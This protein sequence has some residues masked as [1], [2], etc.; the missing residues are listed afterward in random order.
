MPAKKRKRKIKAKRSVYKGL[1]CG[2]RKELRFLKE[3]ERS[4][5]PLPIKAARTETPFGFYT[6]DFEYEEMFIEVKCKHTFLVLLGEKSYLSTGTLSVLQ[7][8]KIKWVAEHIK[9]VYIIVYLSKRDSIPEYI[10]NEKNIT[11]KFKGGYKKKE[12]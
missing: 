1:Q 11:I 8:T 5:Y 9:P 2:S 6:P 4:K 10:I 12:K 7:W 3:C